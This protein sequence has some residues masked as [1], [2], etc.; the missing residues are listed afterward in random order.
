M[1]A[2]HI[3]VSPDRTC[4]LLSGSAPCFL[5]SWNPWASTRSTCAEGVLELNAHHHSPYRSGRFRRW[6]RTK[7]W[8]G[9]GSSEPRIRSRT[10]RQSGAQNG[11]LARGP[12][13]PTEERAKL[14]PCP[15]LRGS[16]LADLP[17]PLPARP[18]MFLLDSRE[19]GAVPPASLNT[20]V[21]CQ[22]K[23][24]SGPLIFPF[25]SPS[26]GLAALNSLSCCDVSGL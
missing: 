1:A 18:H 20:P 9:R 3:T 5:L 23:E 24:S 7:L 25:T 17:S 14:L 4:P 8:P 26:L 13:A 12:L 15:A 21:C 16:L 2:L 19:A 10:W 6:C 11:S 22:L